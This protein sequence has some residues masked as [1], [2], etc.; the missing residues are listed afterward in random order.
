MTAAKAQFLHQQKLRQR[1]SQPW[2]RR[3]RKNLTWR[4]GLLVLVAAFVVGYPF[5]LYVYA[6]V[7]GGITHQGNLTVVDLKAMSN[8]S[9][10]QD[11]G[12]NGDIPPRFLQLN[13]TR[14]KLRGQMWVPYAAA[15]KVDEFS[16]VYSISNCCFNGPPLVQHFVQAKV[17]GKN[18]V[19]FSD[20]FVD[21][22]GTLHVGVKSVDGHIQSVYRL[23]VDQV[24]AD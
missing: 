7:T 23:D 15:G 8:F 14:V 4:M 24:Q 12:V 10:D 17:V 16:L 3:W 19:N 11:N 22:V 18:P 6:A 13:G 9:M 5:Y 1:R 21:V 2:F 20:G